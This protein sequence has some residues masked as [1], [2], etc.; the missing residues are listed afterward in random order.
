MQH[1]SLENGIQNFGV[2]GVTEMTPSLQ[3]HIDATLSNSTSSK[4]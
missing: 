2:E 4:E 1:L 3:P